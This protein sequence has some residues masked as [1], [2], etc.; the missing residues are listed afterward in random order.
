[1][2]ILY[3]SFGG[4]MLFLL[5]AKYLA[6][7]WLSQFIDR[8]LASV[9]TTSFI[10]WLYQFVLP[11]ARYES[12]H[13]FTSSQTLGAVRLFNCSHSGG[14]VMI[15]H[16]GLY[17]PDDW[18]CWAFFHMLLPF[19]QTVVKCCSIFLPIFELSYLSL[20]DV[21]VLFIYCGYMYYK[22]IPC[23]DEQTLL[24]VSV[25]INLFPV[26]SVLLWLTWKPSL[27]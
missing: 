20:I 8:C 24:R 2:N 16:C 17:F 1:M 13:F 10:K 4:C 19:R 21:W 6:A 15:S 14:C 22:Y 12:F 25:L 23:L 5:L 3:V 18:W 9:D 7:Q 11:S 26:W 27:L